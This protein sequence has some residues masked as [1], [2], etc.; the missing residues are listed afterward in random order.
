MVDLVAEMIGDELHGFKGFQK[1]IFLEE[2]NAYQGVYIDNTLR[3]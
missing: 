2:C 3:E 1:D